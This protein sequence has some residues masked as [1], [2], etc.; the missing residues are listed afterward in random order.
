VLDLNPEQQRAV[1]HTE[2]PLLIL[3]GAGSGKTRVITSRI[4]HLIS[5]NIAPWNILA[6]TFT[7][8]A[9]EEMRRRVSSLLDQR[10]ESVW[11]STFHS[12]C[13]RILRKHIDKLGYNPEFVIYDTSDQRALMKQCLA[14]MKVTERVIKPQGVLTRID[15]AKNALITPEQQ[16]LA[17]TDT[18]EEM[19]ADLYQLYQRKLKE[20]NALDF[21]DLLMKA[22]QLF[23][24]HPSILEYYQRLFQY[25][26]VDEYQDTNHAQYRLV[27]NLAAQHKNICVVGDEDQSIYGWRGAD[28]SN[29]LDFEKDFPGTVMVKLEQNYRSTQNILTAAT[30]VIEYNAHRKG[31]VLWTESGDGEQPELY[32]ARSDFEEARYVVQK[33]RELKTLEGRSWTDFAI[34]YRTNAQSRIF[35]DELRKQRVPYTIFGGTKFY[36]RKE[37]KDVLAY[38]KV[39]VNSQDAVNLKRIIN[40]PARGIG[41]KTLQNLEDFSRQ[42]NIGLYE[43]LSQTDQI[44]SLNQGIKK[45]VQHFY[46]IIEMLKRKYA[47][48]PPTDFVKFVMEESGYLDDLKSEQTLESEARLENLEELLNVI[49][50]YEYQVEDPSLAGFLDQASLTEQTD[51]LDE[52]QGILPLMTFH[53]A[54]GLEFPVVFMVGMEEGLFPHARSLDD[55]GEMEEERRLCY[56]GMTRAMERLYLTNAQR[57]RLYGGEQYNLPSRFLEEIPDE[58]LKKSGMHKMSRDSQDSYDAYSFEDDFDQTVEDLD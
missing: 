45:R 16:S 11:V 51:D 55:E 8:K 13:L 35:E 30:K 56:V 3:A 34:F 10:G 53:L 44:R 29:I 25:I 31:K 17:A 2:G 19:I 18:F 15:G 48:M 47:E 27:K 42:K 36:E 9:A 50:N 4:V 39:I 49:G 6:V 57:R 41:A 32:E 43:T 21:G 54:K 52:S 46:K 7:N 12:T 38:L 23:E 40:S 33:M 37:I 26:M 5:H 14:E 1:Q 24:E 28:I 58:F 20:N 22:V